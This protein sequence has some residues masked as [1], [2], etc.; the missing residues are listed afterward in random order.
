MYLKFHNADHADVNLHEGVIVI[1]SQSDCHVMLQGKGVAGRHCRIDVHADKVLLQPL[2]PE[3]S[4]VLNG[5][6]VHDDVAL[7]AG[8]LLLLGQVGCQVAVNRVGHQN[9]SRSDSDKGTAAAPEPPVRPVRTRTEHATQVRGALPRLVLRGLS[10]PMLGRSFPLRDGMVLG[11]GRDCEVFIESQE[12]SR[13]HARLR[14]R[15]DSVMVE[16]LN[17][18]NGTFVNDERVTMAPLEP[19][20]ELR[21]DTIRFVMVAPGTTGTPGTSVQAEDSTGSGKAWRI[22]LLVL[23]LLALMG[24]AWWTWY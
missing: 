11:R 15:P 22:V 2:D 17:S 5:R 20:D 13:Q 6:Q 12:I 24:W 4:C 7:S 9:T 19:G 21:L 16:D 18:T 8:D 10:G 1:G 23:V 3:A 14:V